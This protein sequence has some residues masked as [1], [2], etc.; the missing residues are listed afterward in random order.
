MAGSSVII[1]PLVSK[2][3]RQKCQ[4]QKGWDDRNRGQREA[5]RSW[6]VLHGQLCRWQKKHEPKTAG[7]LLTLE[8]ARK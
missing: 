1:R 7:G 3:G 6:K 8:K 4:R 5:E 2:G